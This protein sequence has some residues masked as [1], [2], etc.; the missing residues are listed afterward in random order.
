M[1]VSKLIGQIISSQIFSVAVATLVGQIL[2]GQIADLAITN[3]KIGN[4]AVGTL[5]VA[6]QAITTSKRQ[7]LGSISF[8]ATVFALS[9]GAFTFFHALGVIPII[10]VK[11]IGEATIAQWITWVVTQL[12]ADFSTVL[13]Y[14]HR[15]TN[16][17]VAVTVTYF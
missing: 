10:T 3:A 7:L 6:D 17:I 9:D 16:M 13:T 11:M 2:G 1:D 14:N 8:T 15:S 5:K 12:D 4:L